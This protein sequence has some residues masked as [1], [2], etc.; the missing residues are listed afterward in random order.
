M[1]GVDE[2]HGQAGEDVGLAFLGVA[3]AC[4]AQRFAKLRNTRAHVTK[5]TQ[6]DAGRLMGHRRFVRAR[7]TGQDH[8]RL[9]QPLARTGRGQQHQVIYLCGCG[10]RR[11]AFTPH[12]S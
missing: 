11:G 6:H 7:L 9:S 4:F 5:I 10:N 2:S 1:A 12:K 3:V 8:P